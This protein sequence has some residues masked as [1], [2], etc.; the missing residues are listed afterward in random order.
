MGTAA[1]GRKGFKGRAAVSGERPIGAASCR[2]QHNQASCPPPPPRAPSP[3][4]AELLRGTPHKGNSTQPFVAFLGGAYP[5]GRCIWASA[6]SHGWCCLRSLCRARTTRVGTSAALP[7]STVPFCPQ[8]PHRLPCLSRGGR[9]G[10]RPRD[11]PCQERHDRAKWWI[12]PHSPPVLGLQTTHRKAHQGFDNSKTPLST[13]PDLCLTQ[14]PP[15]PLPPG[16][17]YCMVSLSDT[18]R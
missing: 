9:C 12:V 2:Q 14:P 4:G 3:S 1:C 5:P 15:P 11:C 13:A 8:T 6:P 10:R 16:W 17:R 18:D 7:P